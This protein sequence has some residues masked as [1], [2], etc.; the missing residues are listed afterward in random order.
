MCIRDSPRGPHYRRTVNFQKH[1]LNLMGQA[2]ATSKVS[3]NT[4]TVDHNNTMLLCHLTLFKVVLQLSYMRSVGR[5]KENRNVGSPIGRHL[6][7]DTY[8]GQLKRS[9]SDIC[10]LAVKL[11]FFVCRK[12]V[13]EFDI[14][15]SNA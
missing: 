13:A 2:A 8:E 5:V 10:S 14:V 6:S 12:Q 7:I 15:I 9:R 4:K 11:K 1:S 3:P